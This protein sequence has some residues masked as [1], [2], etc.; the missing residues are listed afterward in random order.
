MLQF[1]FDPVFVRWIKACIKS[2]WIAP[3]V[4]GHAANLFKA[5]Q[6]L[7]QSYPLSP[8]LYVIQASVLSF[9]L[10]RCQQNNE[11]LGLRISH[12]VKNVNH[13]QFADDTILLGGASV[14]SARL[15]K[16]ELEKYQDASGSLINYNKSQILSW[17]CNP[18]DLADISR[19]IGIKGSSQWVDFKYLGVPIF[20][21]AP[22]VSSWI[23]LMEKN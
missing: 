18:R 1:G 4:N 17:N 21:A 12:G 7:H 5:S 8:M 2:S 23:P 3:L 6:G 22:K 11:L 9:Q 13:A 10:D 15:F 19:I 14:A 16:R 20:K